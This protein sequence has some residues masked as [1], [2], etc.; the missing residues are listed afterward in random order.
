MNQPLLKIRNLSVAL[1]KGADR[2][3]AVHDVSLEVKP[4]EILASSGNPV[5]ASPC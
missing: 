5:R 3:F 2:P 1:P 4:A